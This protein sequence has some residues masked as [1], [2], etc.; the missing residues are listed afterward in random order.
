MS[1]KETVGTPPAQPPVA[2]TADEFAFIG[3][4]TPGGSF[5]SPK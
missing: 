5:P 1:T 2:T 3:G 4:V